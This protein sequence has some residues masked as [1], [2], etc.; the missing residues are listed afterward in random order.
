MLMRDDTRD[1]W[2][3]V[4]RPGDANRPGSAWFRVGAARG[5]FSIRPIASQGWIALAC[6]VAAWTLSSATIWGWG[7]GSGAFSAEFAIMATVL[8][9]LIVI[10]GFIR[11][12]VGR[13]MELPPRDFQSR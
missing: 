10:A 5:K 1:R 12:V 9:A 6:F 3:L 2:F 8:I 7:Y 13:M 4:M 11:L